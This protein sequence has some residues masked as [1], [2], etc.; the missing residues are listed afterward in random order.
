MITLIALFD[1]ESIWHSIVA[2]MENPNVKIVLS[3]TTIIG[4]LIGLYSLIDRK[5]EKRKVKI[6]EKKQGKK[7]K[8]VTKSSQIISAD[9]INNKS[10]TVYYKEERIPSFS[11]TKLAFWNDGSD[12]FDSNYVAKLDP[13][14]I[15]IDKDFEFIDKDTLY[16][17]KASG[18]ELDYALNKD[19]SENKKIINVTFNLFAPGHGFVVKLYHTANS[20][21]CI[22]IKGSFLSGEKIERIQESSLN[23]EDFLDTFIAFYPRLSKKYLSNDLFKRYQNNYYLYRERFRQTCVYAC[24][25]MIIIMIIVLVLFIF[26]YISINVFFTLEAIILLYA[27][28]SFILWLALKRPKLPRKFIDYM[29]EE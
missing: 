25:S 22:K 8:F 24:Y 2:F 15:E 5:I 17:D 23:S 12:G 7:P 18:V 29:Y 21:S 26:K 11:I 20:G 13:L 9:S 3:I 6:K 27:I 4:F 10:I 19:G 1:L 14:R 16:K 28:S